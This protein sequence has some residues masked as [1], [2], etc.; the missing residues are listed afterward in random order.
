MFVAVIGGAPARSLAQRIDEPATRCTETAA[1]VKL[2][3]I[4]SD[5]AAAKNRAELVQSSALGGYSMPSTFG[6]LLGLCSLKHIVWRT[7]LEDILE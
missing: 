1:Q 4:A 3:A 6:R 7:T 5:K 2:A